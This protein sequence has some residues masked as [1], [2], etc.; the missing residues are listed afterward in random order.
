MHILCVLKYNEDVF[1][2]ILREKLKVV[3]VA[4]GKEIV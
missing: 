3:N 4:D 2:S 1:A